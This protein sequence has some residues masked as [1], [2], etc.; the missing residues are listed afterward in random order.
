MA[1]DIPHDR[2]FTKISPQLSPEMEAKSKPVLLPPRVRPSNP[3]TY[4]P[5]TYV[6]PP[7]SVQH[8]RGFERGA[9]DDL[10][11]REPASHLSYGATEDFHSIRGYGAT[12]AR[13]WYME[14]PNG[15]RHI[16]DLY[17]E[18]W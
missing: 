3:T 10:L 15:V 11:L 7:K 18:R 13:K 1:D 16:I 2:A 9:P 8:F 14:L 6:L 5:Q 4:D 17:L 12:S